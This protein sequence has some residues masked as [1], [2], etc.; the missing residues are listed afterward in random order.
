MTTITG[1]A[2]A[3][4]SV[5]TNSDSEKD[6]VEFAN[7][8]S[9]LRGWGELDSLDLGDSMGVFMRVAWDDFHSG[10]LVNLYF[11]ANGISVEINLDFDL[12]QWERI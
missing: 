8:L 6:I 5:K 3:V 4:F 2:N 7:S 10:E 12:F 1:K 9:I 11:G